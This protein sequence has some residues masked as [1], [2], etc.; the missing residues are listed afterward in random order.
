MI[1]MELSR[2]IFNH[3]LICV[4]RDAVLADAVLADAVLARTL[5]TDAVPAG[6]ERPDLPGNVTPRTNPP[7]KDRV[8]CRK[9]R[10]VR[11]RMAMAAYA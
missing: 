4:E 6:A 3:A 1:V 11:S 2:E 8:A 5:P 10:R 7:P 9:S